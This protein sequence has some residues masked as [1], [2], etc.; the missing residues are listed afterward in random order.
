MEKSPLQPSAKDSPAN[1]RDSAN[2]EARSETKAALA[3]KLGIKPE[4]LISGP[5]EI[6]PLR[7]YYMVDWAGRYLGSDTGLISGL[8]TMLVNP[9]YK[10]KCRISFNVT[11]VSGNAS[12]IFFYPGIG[13]IGDDTALGIA[14]TQMHTGNL[15]GYATYWNSNAVS[16]SA[17]QPI[18][19]Y[20]SAD[21]PSAFTAGG[22]ALCAMNNGNSHDDLPVYWASGDPNSGGGELPT[23][24]QFWVVDAPAN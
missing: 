3:Q 1:L 23:E 5:D 24:I 22:S 13:A 7:P 8:G 14:T 19:G 18:L 15:Q 16:G 21:Y 17:F 4:H 10:L 6:V 20:F 2:V 12:A 11:P 9:E